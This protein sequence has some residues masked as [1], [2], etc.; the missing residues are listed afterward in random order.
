[1]PSPEATYGDFDIG[2]DRGST[3]KV[4]V[5]ARDGRA[6]LTTNGAPTGGTFS[7]VLKLDDGSEQETPAIAYNASAATVQAALA[8]LAAIPS[9]AVLC[10][11][12]ALPTAV[13]IEFR[14]ELTGMD[15]ALLTVED[16][17]LTGGTN[18]TAEI[19]PARQALTGWT[20]R[21]TAK[22]SVRDTDANAVLKA[23]N[24]LLGG[25]TLED[26]ANGEALLE[27]TPT[28]QS[29]L[30]YRDYMLRCDFKAES[31]DSPVRV[32]LLASG[33]LRIRA[34]VTRSI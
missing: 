22:E 25:I 3:R 21:F 23:D 9:G 11:G 6:V 20:V 4:R 1:M 19:A 7:L 31:N 27:I 8:Y 5:V 13:Y 15:P 33:M 17:N 18:P 26:A 28:M 10:S 34:A 12:G 2:M 30:E 24:D 32:Y 29:A 14:D 16:Q